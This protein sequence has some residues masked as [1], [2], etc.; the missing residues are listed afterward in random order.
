MEKKGKNQKKG[1]KVSRNRY[2]RFDWAAKYM[3]RNKADFAI[4]EGLISVLV[5]EKVTIVDLLESESNQEYKDD[6]FNRVDIKARD[7]KG[8][9]ILVEIQ[10]SRELDYLQRV[11]Y[12]VAKAITEH[13]TVGKGY[14]GV[15][16]VLSINILYY[17]LGEGADYL[18]HGQ[19]EFV[20]VHTGDTLRLTQHEQNDLK[21]VAPEDVFPE[22]YIIR[23]NEFDQMAVTPLDEWLQYLKDEYIKPDTTVPGLKEARERLEYLRMSPDERRAY[24][25]YLDTLVRDTDVL[26]TK[27][28]EAEI[29]GMKKGMEK[30]ME[31]GMAEANFK[32]ARKMKSKGFSVED[33]SDITGLTPEEIAS[34]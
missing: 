34:I 14:L 23:V 28:L 17:D 30:G 5:G 29:T 15:K 16:K 22:Y 12:G 13:M 1:S 10:Q 6:K 26:R 7:S 20:G 19:A 18:Y 33:I 8:Q 2:I 21:V 31:K 4:F 32:N 3:L 9:I 11:L 27:L 25:N 24:D